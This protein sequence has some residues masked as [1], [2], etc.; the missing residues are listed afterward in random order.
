MKI[1]FVITWVDSNDEKWLEE[2]RKYKDTNVNN[3]NN[4]RYRDWDTLKYWFRAVEQN[5]SWVNHIYFITFGHI[6]AWL[7]VQH[8]KLK[9]IKHADYI[10]QEYLPTFNSRV[11]ELH[12][13][14]IEG[15]S[16]NFV[17]FNDDMFLI[18]K[19]KPEDFFK[20][21]MPCDSLVFNAIVGDYK[22]ISDIVCNDIGVINKYFDKSVFLK[23]NRKKF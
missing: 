9:V 16:E 11:I 12:M 4:V 14:K 13:H 2:K 10:P 15:L 7:N 17:Y 5:A 22:G 19:V 18:D 20:N 8:P 1:D 23:Q 3:I 21:D 6:P